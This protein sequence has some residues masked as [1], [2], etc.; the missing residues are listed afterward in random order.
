M[1][2]NG[3]FEVRILADCLARSNRSVDVLTEY[4]TK[5]G[6]HQASIAQPAC[7][8]VQIGLL[9][10][11]RVLQ[12]KPNVVVGHSSGEINALYTVSE[13]FRLT[14]EKG[15]IAAAYAAGYITSKEA[16]VTAYYRGLAVSAH[17]PEGAMAALGVDT[18]VALNMISECGHSDAVWV[19][20]INSPSS[21]TISGE[22]S[23]IDEII[24]YADQKRVFARKLKT[25]NKA[26]HTH[27]MVEAGH[28]YIRLLQN[29]YQKNPSLRRAPLAKM[30]SSVTGSGIDSNEVASAEYW[31]QNL[32]SRVKF[33]E[34]LTLS[35]EGRPS[36]IIEIGPHSALKGPTQDLLKASN[37]THCMYTPTMM[38]CQ[39]ND[40]SLLQL[41][42][43]LFLRGI[44]APIETLNAR[45]PPAAL[46]NNTSCER[47][48]VPDLPPYSWRRGSILWNEGRASFEYRKRP[49]PRHDLLGS[50]IAG[51]SGQT[52]TWRNLLRVHDVPWLRDHKLGDTIVFPAAGYMAMAV[53]AFQQAVAHRSTGYRSI[54][55]QQ[56]KFIQI[57]SFNSETTSVEIF[58]EL[59]A[60]P[61]TLVTPS[62]TKHTF[63]ISSFEAGCSTVHAR[64]I[65]LLGGDVNTRGA[66]DRA[67]PETVGG[68]SSGQWY[69]RMFQEGLNFGPKFQCLADIRRVCQEDTHDVVASMAVSD[70][71]EASESRY[72]MH[73]TS[74]D[75]LFQ[76]S[77]ISTSAATP[78]T[79][80][81]KIPV[82]IESANFTFAVG[83][84]EW[85]RGTIRARSEFAS[86]HTALAC[87]ELWSQHG[88]LL[89]VKALQIVPWQKYNAGHDVHSPRQPLMEIVWRPDIT[90]LNSIS[91]EQL[92]E[93]IRTYTRT[94]EPISNPD[95]AKLG[96]LAQFLCHKRPGK[97][98]I[99]HLA[100]AVEADIWRMADI[101]RPSSSLGSARSYVVGHLQESEL[102]LTNRYGETEVADANALFDVILVSSN[103][104]GK[105]EILLPLLSHL[106]SKGKI[107]LRGS[108]HAICGLAPN[109]QSH[110]MIPT[111]STSRLMIAGKPTGGEYANLMPSPATVFIVRF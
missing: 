79:L 82:S 15:E 46:L 64:G 101:L 71:S 20:C 93:V 27:H 102:V 49:Y 83:M 103:T 60:A 87:S 104:E 91:S 48:V 35:L 98:D 57:L 97:L 3:S 72:L 61:N 62:E 109:F 67:L 41:V 38:K 9:E 37:R 54:Q 36:V 10:V 14:R 56:I 52:H 63:T 7:S 80:R 47:R 88:T 23:A 6:V 106:R 77:I 51:G 108:S 11:L 59:C 1:R 90:A 55:L 92:G 5:G 44:V 53:E 65:I 105:K 19:A 111:S 107:L 16:I 100:P 30:I 42:G 25:D 18:E 74:V 89:K 86:M 34:A 50:L 95:I 31:R 33:S 96:V 78:H 22:C 12:I 13:A 99:L 43:K 68:L 66:A 8:A 76:A 69:R 84:P 40:T 28:V 75:A 39:E 81:G 21:V 85:S 45:S 94:L 26:Y 110:L 24:L 4:D 29:V 17:A 2:R 73:P 70:H 58:T 32:Q